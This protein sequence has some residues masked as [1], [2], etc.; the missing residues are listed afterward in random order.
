MAFD[1]AFLSAVGREINHLAVGSR[2]D[3]IYQPSREE[4]VI[5]LS[6]AAFSG[7]LYISVRSSSP[8][9]HFTE[10]KIENP[11][12]PPMFCM[13]L[14][15][16]LTSSKLLK[17]RQSG[18]ERALYLDFE[19][20]NDF[21]DS[22]VYTLAAELIGRNANLILIDQQGKIMDSVRRTD[23]EASRHIMPGARYT[24]PENRGL[25][26]I[27]TVEYE[28]IINT[29]L[30]SKDSV[31]DVFLNNY[32]GISPLAVNE[33][34]GEDSFCEELSTDEIKQI[35]LNVIDFCE[36]LKSEPK[37][38]VFW[39]NE[40][41]KD[42]YF[43]LPKLY[44]N[45]EF[46]VYSTF[47]NLLDE[48]YN[49]RDK[50]ERIRIKTAALLKSA[51]TLLSRTK[52]R[53]ANQTEELRQTEDREQLRVYGELIKA[54]LHSI[55]NGDSEV[56]VMNYY[57]ETCDNITIK[58]DP[59][60]SPVA[61]SQ[62]YF[63]E[64]RKANVARVKLAELIE[65]GE[66]EKTY[67]ESVIHEIEAAETDSDINQIAE[68]LFEGGYIRRPKGITLSK[69]DK[70]PK[71]D[72]IDYISTDGFK[73]S[74]GRN[75]IQN[76][77]LTIKTA[78][79]RDM[80][81]HVKDIPGAHVIVF[82]DGNEIP[83]TTLDEAARIAAYHSKAAEGVT[84]KVDYL[85]AKKVKKPNGAK[86]GMVIYENYNTAYVSKSSDILCLKK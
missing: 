71:L 62:K 45:A 85:P 56:E 43:F 32:C 25:A 31:F 36:R 57:S 63:K 12:T 41:K 69:R 21:G 19:G 67:L 40:S 54:N 8:R 52:R 84:V 59:T 50:K 72:T 39:Q 76:D 3:K 2:V 15:K 28:N 86:P 58:L 44:K 79:G 82:A 77:L 75:N 80:W 37:P 14:R 42:Y 55:K 26:D 10:Q 17:V 65:K 81:F 30:N 64:Y 83:D 35:A 24:P 78:G 61:N 46:C 70:K 9:I 66:S 73:I 16:R 5:S 11:P 51:N 7:R 20:R 47:S 23:V 13:R 68:E 18:F 74:V 29:L 6:S 4:L 48:F 27:S 22:V 34:I 1:G 33:I 49:E 38:I 53:L 60:I